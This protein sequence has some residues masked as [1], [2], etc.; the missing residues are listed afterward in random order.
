ME[1]LIW[2]YIDNQCSKEEIRQVESLISSDQS[3]ANLFH[4]LNSM[5]IQLEKVSLEKMSYEFK[6]K[7]IEDIQQQIRT[8]EVNKFEVLPLKWIIVLSIVAIGTL[9]LTPN[10]ANS[11]A[12]LLP[13]FLKI[14]PI[15]ITYLGWIC[16]GFISLT[17]IDKFLKRLSHL[18]KLTSVMV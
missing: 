9:I 10:L 5:N 3:F 7:L 2:K 1:E 8:V 13:I 16:T 12:T 17:L 6:N 18:R 14:D 15:F 11:K 4:Q